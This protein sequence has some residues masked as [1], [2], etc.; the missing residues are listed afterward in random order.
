MVCT[1]VVVLGLPLVV[2]RDICISDEVTL[3]VV[4]VFEGVVPE[5]DTGIHCTVL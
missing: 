4:F 1:P 3:V 2:Q 5:V